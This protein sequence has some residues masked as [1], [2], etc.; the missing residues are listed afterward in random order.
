MLSD[1]SPIKLLKRRLRQVLPAAVVKAH[2]WLRYELLPF[3]RRWWDR[4]AHYFRLSY[5]RWIYRPLLRR[6]LSVAKGAYAGNRCFIIGNAPSVCG[7]DLA[8]LNHEYTMVVNRGFLLRGQGLKH[9]TFYG[10]SDHNAYADYGS[11]IPADFADHTCIFGSVPWQKNASRLNVMAM[12]T[13]RSRR[14]HMSAGFFQFNLKRPVAHSKTVVLQMMQM[15]VYAGFSEIYIIG[16][17]ND[18]SMSNMHFYKDTPQEK[19]NM[20][21]WGLDPCEDN[22]KAFA[23]AHNLLA[24]KGVHVYN[25]GVGGKLQALPRVNYKDLFHD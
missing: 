15:A 3:P 5:W 21:V 1:A 14:K 24:K 17:D 19:H 7:M 9:A 8:P 18:F 6:Q 13:E 25:A 4:H 23:A 2:D 10:I 16:V 11:Q 22:E 12:Y 20:R